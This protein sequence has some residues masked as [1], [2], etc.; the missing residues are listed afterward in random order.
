MNK[1]HVVLFFHNIDKKYKHSEDEVFLAIKD[2]MDAM[3]Y[4]QIHVLNINNSISDTISTAI[5]L[6]GKQ[7]LFITI[8]LTE[9]LPKQYLDCKYI[10]FKSSNTILTENTFDGDDFTISNLKSLFTQSAITHQLYFV[11]NAK[12][13]FDINGI[14]SS[15]CDWVLKTT[16]TN[17]PQVC[18]V[19]MNSATKL[20]TVVAPGG[21][22]IMQNSNKYICCQICN[23]HN[24]A[25]VLDANGNIVHKANNTKVNPIKPGKSTL[26]K[27]KSTDVVPVHKIPRMK[28]Y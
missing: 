24:G 22:K 6:Y 13:G 11:G 5:E 4:N 17:Y 16:K 15:I 8:E 19:V 10:I 28:S 7:I 20:Y 18:S 1:P 3:S 23:K 25:K 9:K 12:F 26:T 2:N 21:S 14:A 27:G